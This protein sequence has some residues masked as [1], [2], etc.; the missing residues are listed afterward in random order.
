MFDVQTFRVIQRPSN[1]FTQNSTNYRV[2][3]YVTEEKSVH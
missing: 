2:N 1:K 3:K